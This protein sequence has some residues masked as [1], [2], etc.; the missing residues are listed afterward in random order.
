MKGIHQEDTLNQDLITE[1]RKEFRMVHDDFYMVLTD[2]D[3]KIKVGMALS[4]HSIR[5]KEVL[6]LLC[7]SHIHSGLPE[8]ILPHPID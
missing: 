4:A 6:L 2:T 5:Q 3:M 7:H 1:L 8:I